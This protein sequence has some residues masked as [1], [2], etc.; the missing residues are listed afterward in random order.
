MLRRPI[1][2]SSPLLTRLETHRFHR[3]FH[4][5]S[6]SKDFF[7][8]SRSSS[9]YSAPSDP[10]ITT[11]PLN[12]TVR[13]RS[14]FLQ[15]AAFSAVAAVFGSVGY[16]T[17]AYTADEVDEK[18]KTFRSSI[19]HSSEDSTVTS[20]NVP[21]RVYTAIKSIPCKA[22]SAYLDL[23][24]LIEDHVQEIA[25]PVSDK[26]LPDVDEMSKQAG[27]MTLVLD[28]RGT[29]IYSEWKRETGWCTYKRPGL[30]DFLE[31]MAH[32]YEIVVYSDDQ[33][34]DQVV[35]QKLMEK[36]VRYFLTRSHTKYLDGKH[37][38]DLSKLN[39]DPSKIIYVS[40]N[41]LDNCLQPEN[42]IPIKPWKKEVDDTTLIDLIPFLE[43]VGLSRPEIKGVLAS[44][45]GKDIP[46]EFIER[47]KRVMKKQKPSPWRRNF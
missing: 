7:S 9:T 22:V 11:P 14:S 23:R 28:L 35:S 15:F 20:E 29:L 25:E 34:D 43:F 45:K 26:L 44:Y 31:H 42:S 37:Y 16:A 41:A 36:G 47:S 46:S 40:G 38:R 3:R 27:I 2:R 4:S 12:P 18:T 17:Y 30:D 13:K 33:I 1:T 10:P 21:H 8:S 32:I 39:R 19:S 24:R 6:E 5:P